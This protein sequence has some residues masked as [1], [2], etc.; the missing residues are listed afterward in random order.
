[1]VMNV[2][3]GFTTGFSFYYASAMAGT[4]T[5]YDGLNATGN[6]LATIPITAQNTAERPK[7]GLHK[8]T[9]GDI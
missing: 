8:S 3:S 7:D 1:M 5:V 2:A 9:A 4:V 6:V